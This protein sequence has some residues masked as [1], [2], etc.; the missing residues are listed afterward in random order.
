MVEISR[1]SFDLSVLCLLSK[2]MDFALDNV[3]STENIVEI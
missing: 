3:E 2:H 1:N